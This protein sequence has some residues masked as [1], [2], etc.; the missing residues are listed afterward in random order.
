MTAVSFIAGFVGGWAVRSAV[1]SPHALGVRALDLAYRTKARL[2]RWAA[3]ER[4]RVEDLIAEVR[5]RYELPSTLA[6]SGTLSK[7]D[8]QRGDEER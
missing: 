6:A 8:T 3:V 4:E 1:D 2:S 7:R 5:Q